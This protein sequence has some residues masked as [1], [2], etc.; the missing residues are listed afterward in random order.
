MTYTLQQQKNNDEKKSSNN[1]QRVLCLGSK[2]Q[3]T[4]GEEWRVS[5]F[6]LDVC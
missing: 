2:V 3:G 6:F 5:R 1:Q 4:G